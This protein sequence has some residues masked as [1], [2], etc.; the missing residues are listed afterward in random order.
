MDSWPLKAVE[1]VV[2][3]DPAVVESKKSSA[4]W[5]VFD[6]VT[7]PLDCDV[8]D[9][10]APAIRYEVPSTSWVNEPLMPCVAA[11]VPVTSKKLPVSNIPPLT[12]RSPPKRAAPAV[13]V[14]W[15][16]IDPLT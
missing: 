15:D 6:I 11:I 3:I 14:P 10:F 1:P 8:I 7:A 4:C 13:E 9:I 12:T 5:N 2:N 16:P